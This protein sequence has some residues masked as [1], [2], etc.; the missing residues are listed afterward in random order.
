[1]DTSFSP[2]LILPLLASLMAGIGL[3]G[4]GGWVIIQAT[5]KS[6]LQAQIT[7]AELQADQYADQLAAIE[8]QLATAT[9]DREDLRDKLTTSQAEVAHLKGQ[10]SAEQAAT[11]QRLKDMAEMREKLDKDVKAVTDAALKSSQDH[12]MGLA[13]QLFEQEREL[14][15]AE[16]GK[17][18]QAMDHQL[19]PVQETLTQYQNRLTQFE[20]DSQAGLHKVSQEVRHVAELHQR[21]SVE[22]AKLTNAL[23]A[24]PKTRGRWGEHQLRNV[25]ELAGMADHVDFA[26]EQSFVTDEGTRQRPDA[27]INIPGGRKIIVDAKTSMSAYLDAVETTDEATRDQLL[28]KHAQELRTHVKQLG[29]K[30]YWQ[31]LSQTFGET[32]DMVAMFIPGDN[33]YAAAI[34][35]DPNLFSDALDNRVLIVTPTTLFAVAKAI[36]YG[37]QQADISEDAQKIAADGKVLYERLVTTFEPAA[38][39]RKNLDDAVKSYNSFVSSLESRTLPAARKLANHKGMITSK[40][41]EAIPEIETHSNNFKSPEAAAAMQSQS[42]NH[43]Q[44]KS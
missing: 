40:T 29:S 17:A 33:F 4:V 15:K 25:L 14:Q 23:R 41:V 27:T 42:N 26:T 30:A 3:G 44:E 16:L 24:A 8:A 22:T 38:K 39:L 9:Q 32:I 21:V 31:N 43:A 2:D 28:H 37:W 34:E 6:R 19:K 1:M 35:R 18:R 13:K 11:D 36:A 7:Q 12:F 10:R 20:K 5:V